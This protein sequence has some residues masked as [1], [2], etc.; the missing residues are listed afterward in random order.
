MFVSYPKPQ[1]NGSHCDTRFVVLSGINLMFD[2]ATPF[3]FSI[4]PIAISEYP[5]HSY[6]IDKSSLTTN[7]KWY[8]NLDYKMSGLGSNSCGPELDTQYRLKEKDIH[9]NF[10]IKRLT[11]SNYFERHFE[12]LIK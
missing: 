8:F 11:T 5:S 3:S 7:G 10:T 9:F 6:M 4:S 1:E 2:S 12:Q